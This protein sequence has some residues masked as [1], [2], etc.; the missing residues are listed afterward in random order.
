LWIADCW[1]AQRPPC[2][3]QSAIGNRQS[4]IPP[5]PLFIGSSFPTYPGIPTT[6]KPYPCINPLFIGSSF[7]TT[8]VLTM[9]D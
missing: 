8:Y 6:E 1:A 4:A 2:A 3:L 7:P 9:L 5:D